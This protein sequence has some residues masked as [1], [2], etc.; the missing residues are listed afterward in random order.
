MKCGIIGLPNVGKSTFFNSLSKIKVKSSN[1]PFCTIEPNIA[2]VEVPD[3]RLKELNEIINSKKIIP[4]IVKIVDIAG[5]VRGAHKG[6]GLGNKFLSNIKETQAII[7]VLRL[8]KNEN[9]IHVENNIDPIRDKEIVDLELQIK[10]IE[11]LENYL[12]KINKKIKIGDKNYLKEKNLILKIINFL[13]IGKN[14]R[15]IELDNFEKDIFYKLNLLTAKPVL[16]LCNIDY[17]IKN[18]EYNEYN[19][20]YNNINLLKKNILKEKAKILFISA[21][22]ESKI[23]DCQ[24]NIEKEIL[25]KQLNI[26]EPKIYNLIKET[27]KI[28][29]LQSFFT[30]STKE[31]KSWTIKKGT[32]AIEASSII[33][34]DI[35]KGFIRAEIIHFNDY[36]KYKSEQKIKNIGKMFLEGKNYKIK[37]GDIVHFRFNI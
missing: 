29:N 12:E 32:T 2:I 28:L 27:Y 7:H 30:C 25:L 33:H 35:K 36:I 17:N 23:A 1:F 8:F 21:E 11:F 9:I 24:N 18:N 4:S 37:D 13:N 3:L 10:D 5:L 20:E 22:I 6:K 15:E 34:S 16:Y 26:Q 19:N 31:I 14:A